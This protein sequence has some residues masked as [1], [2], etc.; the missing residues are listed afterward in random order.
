MTPTAQDTNQNK[1]SE[2]KATK[3]KPGAVRQL[4]SGAA[5]VG[6]PG[7]RRESLLFGIPGSSEGVTHVER[8]VPQDEP[9]Q[10]PPNAELK[11]IGKRVPRYD[12]NYKASGAAKY[13]SDVRLPGILYACFVNGEHPHARIVSIDTS[14][15][16]RHPEVKAVHVI[17]HIRGQAE[18]ED[19]SR[20]AA[21]RYPIVRY[22]GQPIAAVAAT[23]LIWA[24]EAAR[25]VKVQYDT[26]PGDLSSVFP[27]G[28]PLAPALFEPG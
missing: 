9:P 11:V 27:A 23:T 6:K 16:E 3:N 22:S 14:E 17:E 4:T 18:L 21:S 10:L 2:Q 26:M 5:T 19:K 25:L 13:P 12:G 24:R 1:A 15:A 20:E 28:L 8:S 7:V